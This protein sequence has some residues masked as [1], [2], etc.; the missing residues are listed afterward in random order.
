MAQWWTARIL[1]IISI[2][3]RSLA[4]FRI[5]LGGLLIADLVIR[6]SDLSVWM[7]D[8]G[9]FPRDFIIDWNN[10]IITYTN[11]FNHSP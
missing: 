9:V 3:L 1:P 4:L 11:I 5:L 2:D 7:T 8:A 6:G 10:N